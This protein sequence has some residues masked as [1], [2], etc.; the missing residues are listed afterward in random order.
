MSD[1][2]AFTLVELLVVIA[3]IGILVSLLLPAVQAAREAARR[4]SC[5]NNMKNV[6]LALINYH[7]TNGHFPVN[8]DY[9]ESDDVLEVD[10]ESLEEI[11]W[12]SREEAG[13]L[14]TEGLDG[15]GWIVRVLPFL[16]EQV[17]FDQFDIPNHG[18][19]GN[20]REKNPNT[21]GM[22]WTLDPGF[23][24]ALGQQPS[25]LNCPSDDFA[26]PRDDQYPYTDGGEVP[27]QGPPPT[28]ATTSYKGNAGDGDFEFQE[29]FVAAPGIDT[30]DPLFGCYA[31]NDCLGVFWRASYIKGGVK[32]RQISDG[33]SN[34]F[35]I[36]ESS[37]V[38]GN[39]AAWSSDGDWAITSVPLNWNPDTS[40]A[41]TSPGAP[42]CWTQYRGFRSK[43]P[44][45]ANFAFNDGSVS[46]VNDGVEPLVYR[47]LSTRA[48]GEIDGL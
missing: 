5:V 46:Y 48:R 9:F 13:N 26:G 14:P 4:A 47:A 25:V 42:Q 6:A 40:G 7:D 39:S 10:P 27:I 28:I 33:T 19:N 37:P 20:W 22:N 15:G 31:S 44:G 45:G 12:V 35:L 1:R 11:R 23:V 30:Y 36:G 41:C 18:I 34:T 17:L 43:H 3:I 16:E 21:L 8:E 24:T 38:D 32:L 2:H 29:A